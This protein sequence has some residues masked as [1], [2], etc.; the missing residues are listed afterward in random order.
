MRNF[1]INMKGS[2]LIFSKSWSELPAEP[3]VTLPWESGCWR[4]IIGGKSLVNLKPATMKRPMPPPLF[5]E[6]PATSQLPPEK[7]QR[8]QSVVA[9]SW[10]QV[11]KSGIEDSWTEMRDSQFQIAL[12]RWLDV[13][14][15]LPDSCSVV[16]QLRQVGDVSHQL[17]M[18]RDIFCR[19]APQTLLKR[20]HSF[21]VS[22]TT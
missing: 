16:V 15:Q 6:S 2:Q 11:V 4:H 10:K 20:C 3:A 17:R 14:L 18:L 13:L 8:A 7:K 21:C 19:K 1:D 12:K 5:Y 22:C 9:T